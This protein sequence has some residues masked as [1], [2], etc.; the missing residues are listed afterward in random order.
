MLKLV[1]IADDLTGALDTGVK[2]AKCGIGTRIVTDEKLLNRIAGEEVAVLCAPTRHVS[3]QDAYLDLYQLASQMIRAGIPFIYKKTDSVLRGNIGSELEAL[4]RAGGNT[5]LPFI[6]AFPAMGRVTR[7]GVQLLNGVP[8]SETEFRDDPLNPI[9]TSNIKAIISKQS[10]VPVRCLRPGE[11]LERPEDGQ[12]L[13]IDAETEQDIALIADRLNSLGLLR[14]TAGCAG[15]AEA[16]RERIGFTM[17]PVRQPCLKRTMVVACGSVNPIT[18]RQ[19]EYAE[20]HGFKRINLTESQKLNSARYIEEGCLKTV[21]EIQQYCAAG[22]SVIF[23]TDRLYDMAEH[24]D[25]MTDGGETSVEAMIAAVLQRLMDQKL[26]TS[27]FVTGGDT[28]FAFLRRIGCT[29]LK[30]L[31]EVS[32]GVVLASLNYHGTVYE[33]LSKS[34]GFGEPDILPSL[35]KIYADDCNI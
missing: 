7:G 29:E 28:F 4:L 34:G 19:L 8:I 27:L 22:Y 12:I 14:V 16:L 33:V 15:F 13:I 21:L 2:F 18:Q 23:G 25:G 1:V 10:R 17:E 32:E 9:T 11:L 6:P 31:Y 30:P 3:P 5:P 20:R 24:S 35:L 26:D